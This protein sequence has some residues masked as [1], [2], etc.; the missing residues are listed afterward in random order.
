MYIEK[1]SIYV[2]FNEELAHKIYVVVD[3]SEQI[4]TTTKS[5]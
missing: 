4:S 3:I 5:I 1:V 2:K